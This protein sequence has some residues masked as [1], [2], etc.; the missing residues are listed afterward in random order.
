M[1]L[2]PIFENVTDSGKM[3]QTSLE[4]VPESGI[5]TAKAKDG[6]FIILVEDTE[7]TENF[8]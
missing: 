8:I 6:D 3:S 7:R 5:M 2:V 4:N 1:V